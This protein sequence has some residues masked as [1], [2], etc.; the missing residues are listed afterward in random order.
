MGLSSAKRKFKHLHFFEASQLLFS[1]SALITWLDNFSSTASEFPVF[2]FTTADLLELSESL[3]CLMSFRPDCTL[4]FVP[5]GAVEFVV[6]EL[7]THQDAGL[8]GILA[9]EQVKTEES[10]V[11]GQSASSS[12]TDPQLMSRYAFFM[13]AV[14]NLRQVHGIPLVVFNAPVESYA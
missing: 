4:L 12:C 1:P 2:V 7:A 10:R 11:N 8:E 13:S 9:L 14:Y 5:A 6:R 3:L